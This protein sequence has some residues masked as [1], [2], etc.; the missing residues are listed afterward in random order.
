M[1]R[2]E[3]VIHVLESANP[4]ILCLQELSGNTEVNPKIKTDEI[5]CQKLGMYCFTEK[6]QEWSDWHKD[7][8]SNGIFSR[9][10][11]RKKFSQFLRQPH[12]SCVIDWSKEGR[13]YLETEL[14][15]YGHLLTIG[16]THLSYTHGFENQ[17]ERRE[18]EENLKKYVEKRENYIV[19][20][21]FNSSPNSNIIA[22]LT[23]NM[24]HCGPP[25]NE[26]T[27]TTKPFEHNG[28]KETELRWRL[29]Y[30][31]ASKEIKVKNAYIYNT[32]ASDHLPIIVEFEI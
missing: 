24:L 18:E 6:S 15:I 16:T 10:P 1:E 5:I 20:G 26:N 25:M 13:V 31:F 3:N 12:P 7:Y 32:N 19:S 4:D 14:D 22:Y 11:I 8:Q 17:E 29:D 21:D 30:V 23:S 2:I 9:F 27:W 28:F